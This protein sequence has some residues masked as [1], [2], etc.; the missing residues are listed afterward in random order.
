MAEPRHIAGELAEIMKRRTEEMDPETDFR[1]DGNHPDCVR[2]M[3]HVCED[4]GIV[5]FSRQNPKDGRRYW[6]TARCACE[7][8]AMPD[9]YRCKVAGRVESH[10]IPRWKD[11]LNPST[12][13]PLLREEDVLSSR[14]TAFCDP[15]THE[16]QLPEREP[17]RIKYRLPVIVDRW[18]EDRSG[19]ALL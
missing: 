12:G 5:W 15:V 8:T 14:L 16:L 2:V 13:L 19:K 3:C 17:Y 10:R 9:V 1:L 7:T 18:A 6:F 4:E 11:V